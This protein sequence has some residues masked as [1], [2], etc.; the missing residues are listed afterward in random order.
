LG[1]KHGNIVAITENLDN[2]VSVFVRGYFEFGIGHAVPAR[3]LQ[4]PRDGV[5]LNHEYIRLYRKTQASERA[6]A[7]GR[8]G[9]EPLVVMEFRRGSAFYQAGL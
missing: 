5:S 3:P 8:N 7:F 4:Y 9:P 1:A 6:E 2:I